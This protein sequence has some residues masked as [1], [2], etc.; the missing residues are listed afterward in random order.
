MIRCSICIIHIL[1]GINTGDMILRILFKNGRGVGIPAVFYPN[2]DGSPF[3]YETYY[4][5]VK[6]FKSMVCNPFFNASSKRIFAN[7]V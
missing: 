2:G 3:R 4:L 7:R 6:S 1:P 5:Y